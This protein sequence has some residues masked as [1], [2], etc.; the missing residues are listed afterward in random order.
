MVNFCKQ[1]LSSTH[2]ANGQR[3]LLVYKYRNKN[4][5]IVNDWKYSLLTIRELKQPRRQLN[6]R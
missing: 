4:W 1:K 6:G 5:R 3:L 2:V